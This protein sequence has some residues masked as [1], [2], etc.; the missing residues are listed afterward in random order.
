M[1]SRSI[2]A[3][4][5]PGCGNSAYPHGTH[6]T[7]GDLVD[8][9]DHV[10]S[11]LKLQSF[12]LIGHSMGGAVGLEYTRRHTEQVK[13]FINIEGNLVPEDCFMT[14]QLSSV[15]YEQF[16][17]KQLPELIEKCRKSTNV[18]FQHYAHDNLAVVDPQGLYDYAA[19]TVDWSDNLPLLQH[20]VGLTPPKLFVYGNANKKTLSKTLATLQS[21]GCPV[22]SVGHSDHFPQYDNPSQ[23]A[24]V[25]AASGAT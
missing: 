2:V 14:R 20:Y 16:R 6:L 12:T 5:F 3:F 9:T 25:I 15:P 4:D 23:L 22:A 21:N 10:V 19:S 7:L 17:C 8:I 13:C 18:G 1:G 11:V 24:Q